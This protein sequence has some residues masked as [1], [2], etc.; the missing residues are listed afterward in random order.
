MRA[1]MA[2][3]R[4]VEMLAKGRSEDFS[5]R[6]MRSSS[7]TYSWLAAEREGT[8]KEKPLPERIE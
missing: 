2:D 7:G 5:L 8:S 4:T 6:T 1:V 3:L